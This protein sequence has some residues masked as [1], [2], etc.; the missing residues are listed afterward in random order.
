MKKLIGF[1]T[2]ALSL[3]LLTSCFGSKMMT[4]NGGEVTGTGGKA[5][6]EPT[7]YGKVSV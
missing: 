7:Q 6:V 5:Y 4:A 2:V 1:C 3:F